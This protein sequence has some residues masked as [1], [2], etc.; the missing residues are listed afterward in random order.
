MSWC[1]LSSIFLLS[2]FW[3]S[4]SVVWCL[5]LILGNSQILLLQI[6][7]LFHLFYLLILAFPL[8]ISYI[9]CNCP[10]VLGYSIQGLFLLDAKSWL[11]WEDPDAR[12][13]LWCWEG[14][15]AGGKGD[16]RGWDG[17]MASLTRWTWVWMNSRSWWWTGR[18]GALRFMGSQRVG[19]DWA[20][21][22]NWTELML[23]KTEGRRRGRRRMRWLDSV[24]DSTDMS[25]GKLRE[26]MMDR[27][28]WHAA[29]HGVTKSWT[30]LSDWT[31]L[32]FQF[33][34]SLL[35]CSQSPSF[36]P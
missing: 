10:T 26:L 30:W 3:T 16:D 6:F 15:G 14:L 35:T 2:V 21:E 19:H 25:L 33:E 23:G 27:E 13:R 12:K 5:S 9:F 32:I 7:L 17:W 28:A 29:V 36:F 34:E 1:R 20:T 24:T 18:P 22:L 11:I 4:R 8:H 31:D